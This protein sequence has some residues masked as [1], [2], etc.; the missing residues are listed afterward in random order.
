MSKQMGKTKLF[1]GWS[2]KRK[3]HEPF[4]A[5]SVSKDT[6]DDACM[7]MYNKVTTKKS[8]LHAPTLCGILAYMGLELGET[9]GAIGTQGNMVV[10]EY[11]SHTGKTQVAVFNQTTGKFIAG[12][13]ATSADAPAPY[14]L[15]TDKDSGAALIFALMP[16]ALEDGEFAEQYAALLEHRKAGFTDLATATTHAFVLCDNL[17]R[18][19]ENADSLGQAGIKTT[20]PSTGNVQGFTALNLNRGTYGPTSTLFG[21]FQVLKPGSPASAPAAVIGHGDFVGKYPLAKRKFT[22]AE[23]AM[24]PKLEPWYVIPPEAQ[25]VCLH[26][27]MTSGGAQPMRNFMLRGPSGTGKTESARAIAAG[28]GLPYTHLTCGADFE[29]FDLLGQILPDLDGKPMFAGAAELPTFSDIRMDP[30]TAYEKL[31]GEYREEVTEEQVYA[32]LLEVM[33]AKAQPQGSGDAKQRFRYV[34]TPLVQALRYGWCLEI[35]EPSVISNPGVLVGLNDLLD[36]CQ[37]ATLPTGEVIKRHP[38]CVIVATTNHDYAGCRDVNQSVISR[39]EM[40]IDIDQLDVDTMTE[41][42]CGPTGCKDLTAVRRM[43]ETV[44][45]IAARCRELM[46]RDGSCG[47]RELIAWVQSFM[48]CGDELE[49]AR[50][51]VLSSVSADPENRAEIYNTCLAPIYAA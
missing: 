48:V 46:I 35:Q 30:P 18:R 6:T 40:I 9:A 7:S 1:E 10:A 37:S 29:R 45:S 14:I 27:K 3:L 51:T 11:P 13:F 16:K 33:Q 4:N 31:T 32:K 36:R 8:T 39:M 38:D 21:D 15:K 19:I 25:R 2:F 43:A 12:N 26:A 20:I 44:D 23:Q 47:M 42:A 17:Y 5:P 34:D 49:A 50:H 22:S 28:L 24:I 41:R